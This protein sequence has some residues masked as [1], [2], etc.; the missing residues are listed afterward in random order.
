LIIV[1]K[2]IVTQQMTLTPCFRVIHERNVTL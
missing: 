1:E 2:I